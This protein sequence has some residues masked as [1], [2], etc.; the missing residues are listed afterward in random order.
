MK[1]FLSLFLAVLLAF[2]M[3]VPAFATGEG[4]LDGGGGSM[5]TVQN[6][7]T[8]IPVWMVFV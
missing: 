1:K 5:G 7:T 2:S 3:A 4:N 8:G 6:R